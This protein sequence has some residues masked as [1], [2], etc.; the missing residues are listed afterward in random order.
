MGLRSSAAPTATA[1]YVMSGYAQYLAQ[2]RSLGHPRGWPPAASVLVFPDPIGLA[3]DFDGQ[4]HHFGDFIEEAGAGHEPFAS[5]RPAHAPAVIRSVEE[6]V[7]C[8][9]YQGRRVPIGPVDSQQD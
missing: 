7:E 1:Q 4:L 5:S 2:L 6:T 3:D 9:L 8:A